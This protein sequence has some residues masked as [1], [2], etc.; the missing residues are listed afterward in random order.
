[1]YRP[2]IKGLK[3]DHKLGIALTAYAA[4]ELRAPAAHPPL[5]CVPRRRAHQQ[6][7]ASLGRALHKKSRPCEKC[8]IAARNAGNAPSPHLSAASCSIAYSDPAPAPPAGAI[9]RRASAS[10]A[11]ARR[12]GLNPSPAFSILIGATAGHVLDLPRIDLIHDRRRPAYGA[13][14]V[15]PR[16]CG[17]LRP[18]LVLLLVVLLLVL[19]LGRGLCSRLVVGVAYRAGRGRLRSVT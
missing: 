3:V 9:R 10:A 5:Q 18:L 4:N 12:R 17:R 11:A 19:L 7:Q 13:P 15:R 8:A 2:F 16:W 14:A 1:M 6:M